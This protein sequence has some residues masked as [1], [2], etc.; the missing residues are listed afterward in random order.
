VF[1]R[2]VRLYAGGAFAGCKGKTLRFNTEKEAEDFVR[3]T[4]G[5][6]GLFLRSVELEALVNVSW[7]C[8]EV[9]L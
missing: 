7:W 5:I 1:A 9:Q 4:P 2:R 3:T 8:G 6:W